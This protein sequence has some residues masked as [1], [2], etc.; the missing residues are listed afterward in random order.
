MNATLSDDDSTD[1]FNWAVTVQGIDLGDEEE[2]DDDMITEEK[3][4]TEPPRLGAFTFIAAT[5]SVAAVVALAV[6]I[7]T[8]KGEL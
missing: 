4:T 1:S 8:R 6:V 2:P 3:E 7:L 5:A